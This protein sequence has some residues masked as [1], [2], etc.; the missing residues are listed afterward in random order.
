MRRVACYSLHTKQAGAKPPLVEL[1]D[2]WLQSKGILSQDT[3]SIR[4][5]D[6][7][8]G[9]IEKKASECSKGR[10]DEMI[11][12][13]P[14]ENGSFST[15]IAVASGDEELAISITLGAA[16][17]VLAPSRL[18]I[19][20]PRI[21]RDVLR[22]RC[23]WDYRGTQVS[24]SPLEFQGRDGGERFIQFAWSNSR[25][26]PV[27]IISRIDESPVSPQ[28]LAD[29]ANDLAGLAVVADI[30]EEAAWVV[31]QQKSK[32]WSCY[33]GAVRVYWPGLNETSSCYDH[34]LWTG[35]RLLQGVDDITHATNR[36][37]SQLRRR[38]LSQ[39]AFGITEPDF[40]QTI[41]KAVRIEEIERIRHE[42]AE[43]KSYEEMAEE[44]Y[45]AACKAEDRLDQATKEIKELKTIVE[46]LQYALQWKGAVGIGPEVI[47][48]SEATP[49]ATVEEAVIQAR[50]T[51]GDVLTFGLDVDRGVATLSRDAGPPDKILDYLQTL[52]EFTIAK[53]SGSLGM[54][55][56]KWLE[57]KG[58]LGSIEAE[59][60]MKNA[61]ERSAR[62]WD[63]GNGEKRT[64]ELHLKPSE[65]T[66][67][68]RCVRIYF[69]YD[70]EA[71]KTVLG[72]VGRH[73]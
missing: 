43:G 10:L 1:I 69:E 71:Q 55:A 61:S 13:E 48:P 68:D 65:G 52:G 36:I 25:S 46:N 7:R 42:V 72:W 19:R 26:L 70:E 34:P 58:A 45:M 50:E 60:V 3:T 24:L 64:F 28:G 51:L 2:S 63:Y 33:G 18:D 53:R 32:E 39:S 4:L 23:I 8:V 16:S 22:T 37:R 35:Q 57:G 56:V 59:G 9:S 20:C 73:P 31:T 29:I 66:S 49:P 41:R 30:D 12:L 5:R 27:V 11:L 17:T 14:T 47:H 40:L 15:N 6:G 62:T 67:P 38:I 44:Y 21:V 54:S